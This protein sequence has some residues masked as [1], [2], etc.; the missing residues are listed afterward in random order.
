[1]IPGKNCNMYGGHV[2]QMIHDCFQSNIDIYVFRDASP[3]VE[4]I[5]FG[6]AANLPSLQ[7]KWV[8]DMQWDFYNCI[9]SIEIK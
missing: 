8:I 6:D 5:Y 3:E 1:M 9:F 7:G 2:A 4:E